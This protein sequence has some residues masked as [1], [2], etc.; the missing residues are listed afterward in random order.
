M[1]GLVESVARERSDAAAQI[2]QRDT[3]WCFIS[4]RRLFQT[5]YS[6][7]MS[8]LMLGIIS[9]GLVSDLHAQSLADVAKR[10][11]EQRA[12][13]KQG[14]SKSDEGKKAETTGAM[15]Y[16]NKDLTPDPAAP[17]TDSTSSVADAP[18][19]ETTTEIDPQG[20]SAATGD[21]PTDALKDE[22][23]WRARVAPLHVRI[24]DNLAKSIALRRRIRELTIDLYGI[25]PLNARRAG[26]ETERQRLITD[27]EALDLA[28]SSD[29]QAVKDIEEEGRRAG[30]FPGWFR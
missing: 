15:V 26:V 29:R 19:S 27:A 24:D 28:V 14:Q 16:T 5:S 4:A 12:A 1:R 13:A 9:L 20:T 7:P 17:S 2:A 18:K 21:K 22:T 11:E 25:G 23:Y 30:A 10:A 6:D 8:R 3:V